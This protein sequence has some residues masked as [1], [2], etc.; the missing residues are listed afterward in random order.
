MIAGVNK[1]HDDDNFAMSSWVVLQN[2]KKKKIKRLYSM[3]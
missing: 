1:H 2:I 3:Y